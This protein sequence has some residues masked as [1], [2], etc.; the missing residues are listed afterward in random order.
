M[1]ALGERRIHQLS[2]GQQ[3]R[4]ALARALVIRP[5]CLLLDEPLSN[6][7]TRLRIEMRGEIRRI[8]ATPG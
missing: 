4:V 7:D 6:L 5:R 2:G 3:Q 1:E 8:C